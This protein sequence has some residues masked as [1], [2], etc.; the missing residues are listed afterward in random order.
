M[1]P[2]TPEIDPSLIAKLAER[3]TQ[4]NYPVFRMQYEE[5][6]LRV[7]Y[8]QGHYICHVTNALPLTDEALRTLIAEKLA[9]EA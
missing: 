5:G 9:I 7:L 4:L 6:N 3:L 8:V 2:M 1:A